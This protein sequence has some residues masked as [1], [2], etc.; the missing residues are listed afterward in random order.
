MSENEEPKKVLASWSKPKP[1]QPEQ[2][3][4]P[5]QPP[6]TPQAAPPPQFQPGYGQQQ[7]YY[8]QQQPYYGQ[9]QPYYGQPQPPMPPAPPTAPEP[10]PKKKRGRGILGLLLLATL[11]VA[12]VFLYPRIKA[13]IGPEPG[14]RIE[15]DDR[16]QASYPETAGGIAFDLD[17]DFEIAERDPLDPGE[18]LII[19][20]KGPYADSE[21]LYLVL[22]TDIVSDIGDIPAGKL[23]ELM[24]MA[25]RRM[26]DVIVNNYGL[27]KDYKVFYDKDGDHPTA[28][29]DFTGEDDQAL[30]ITCHVESKLVNGSL[31]SACA[32]ATGQD[33]LDRMMQIYGAIVKG[34]EK[35]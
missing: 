23:S 24:Q 14:D 20:P 6:V 12:G 29:I 27:S 22:N 4:Q 8:N 25:A 17:A 7:P 31:L 32:V 13:L 3:A 11:V 30:P 2:P 16:P 1:A 28:T 9:Q 15:Y 18:T 5:A 21:R 10:A 33:L 26:A 35:Q 34:A 19:D